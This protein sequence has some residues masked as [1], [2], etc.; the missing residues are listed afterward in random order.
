LEDVVFFASHFSPTTGVAANQTKSLH[1]SDTPWIWLGGS[2]P[3]IRGALLRVRNPEIIYATWASSAPVQAQ[4]D[5]ASYYA[6]AER[7]MTRNCSADWIAVTKYVD[8]VLATGSQKDIS[9]LKFD[10]LSAHMGG[11]RS[12]NRSTS[13]ALS[14]EAAAN[15]LLDPLDFYQYYGFQASVLPF[16]NILETQNFTRPATETG[17]AVTLNSSQKAFDA[18]LVGIASL[19][20]ASIP[21]SDDPVAD[22]SWMWQYCSEYGFYQRGDGANTKNI[23]TTFLSLDLFQKQCNQAFGNGLPTQPQVDHINKYGGWNMQPSNIMWTNGEFDPWRTMGVASIEQNSPHRKTT[24][25]I[26]SCN[27]PPSGTD[28]F[29]LVYDN[30]VHVSDMRVLLTPDSNHSNFQTVGFYSPIS[31][32]PFYA[33]LGLFELALDEWLP[34]FHSNSTTI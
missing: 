13:D 34:C 3:G 28:V 11:S 15:F 16:C 30:M 14:N 17:L 32:T 22:R 24:Q 5:M 25:S 6:A 12:F 19:D 8:S 29:G 18:F 31:H 33:G 27:K 10:L 23:E 4:I 21:F 2:Y 26:P 7:S 1:P 20:Y 9:D